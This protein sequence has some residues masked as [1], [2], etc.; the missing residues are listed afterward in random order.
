MT[1]MMFVGL[2]VLGI[3]KLVILYK[4]PKTKTK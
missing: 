1:T 3:G 4:K 2:L